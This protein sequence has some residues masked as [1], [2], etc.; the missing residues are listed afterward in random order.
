MTVTFRAPCGCLISL[1][2]GPN[3]A[4]PIHH[5]EGLTAKEAMGVFL[6]HVLLEETEGEALRTIRGGP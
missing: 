3:E 6:R 5:V 1:D 4:C 2:G